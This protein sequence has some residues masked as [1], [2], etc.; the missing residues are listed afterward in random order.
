MSPSSGDSHDLES[1]GKLLL[2]LKYAFRQIKSLPNNLPRYME[3]I[4][5]IGCTYTIQLCFVG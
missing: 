5:H 4:P 2:Q 1:P 3:F